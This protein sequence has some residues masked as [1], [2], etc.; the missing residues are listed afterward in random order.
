MLVNQ[1]MTIYKKLQEELRRYTF[2][3]EVR[4]ERGYVY[5]SYK[6]DG[7]MRIK[8]I[9][10][11]TSIRQLEA[12]IDKIKKEVGF[13]EIKEMRDIRVRKELAKPMMFA[14]VGEDDG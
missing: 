11:R 12:T 1:K 2:L 14:N 9:P 7:V 4:Y 13:K 5:L 3:T 8:R 10:Y 6:V